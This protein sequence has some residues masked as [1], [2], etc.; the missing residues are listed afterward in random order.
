MSGPT[1]IEW[2]DVVW[3]VLRGCSMAKGSEAGGCLNCYAARDAARYP[4]GQGFARTTP[5]GP[6]WTGRVDALTDK[7]DWPLRHGGTA[8]ARAAGRPSRVF[9]NSTSD[10]FHET[11]DFRFIAAV[12]GVMA[13]SPH[14]FIVL[15][16]RPERRRAF[17][18]W[19]GQAQ[20]PTRDLGPVLLCEANASLWKVEVAAELVAGRPNGHRKPRPRWPLENVIEGTSVEDQKTADLR[21]PELLATPCA[22]RA[23][24]YEPALGPVDFREWIG[25]A[26]YPGNVPGQ[27]VSIDGETWHKAD[28]KCRT[29][30][31]GYPNDPDFPGRV[32]GLDWIIVGGESGPKAR[33]FYVRWAWDVRRQVIESTL[34]GAHAALFVKQMGAV[35]LV[36]ACR[37]THFDYATSF[38]RDSE[39]GKAFREWKDDPKAW[40]WRLGRKGSDPSLWPPELRVREFP[41]RRVA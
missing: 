30:G 36:P 32:P 21:V 37:Q 8:E 17:Y 6:R 20:D 11:V 35:P 16:K 22:L 10:L 41:K 29:C 24:S 38:G 34:E 14:D 3:N 4:W 2:C 18:E 13:Y 23:V 9:V 39:G 1:D 27:C 28:E 25:F 26:S 19:V 31:W 7:L 15:T 5:R 33:P 40:R 12:Y